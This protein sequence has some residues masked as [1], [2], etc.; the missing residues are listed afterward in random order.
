MTECAAARDG[1]GVEDVG[2]R[3]LG[4]IARVEICVERWDDSGS[5][6]IGRGGVHHG[7]IDEGYCE[8][9][10][11]GWMNFSVL[12]V[13]TIIDGRF[14][15]P[16]KAR[17]GYSRGVTVPFLLRAVVFPYSDKNMAEWG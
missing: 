15:H 12:C 1:G 3:V 11:R 17:S 4:G 13:S 14:T 5:R 10:M 16:M 2:R 9:Q 6:D 7:R 8:G